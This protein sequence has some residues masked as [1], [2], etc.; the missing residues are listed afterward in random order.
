M[1]DGA[2]YVFV[3]TEGIVEKRYIEIKEMSNDLV[4]VGGLQDG[5]AVIIKGMT[6]IQNGQEVDIIG[7]ES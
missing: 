6:A 2:Q 4:K 5:E 7:E 3:V 1:N